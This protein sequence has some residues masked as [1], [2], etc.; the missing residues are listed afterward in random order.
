MYVNTGREVQDAC[1]QVQIIKAYNW[2]QDS[3]SVL[4][5]QMS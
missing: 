1:A 5:D 4:Q 2:K 3:E